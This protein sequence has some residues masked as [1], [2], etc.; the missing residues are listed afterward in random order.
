MMKSKLTA[1]LLAVLMTLTALLPAMAG[2][3]MLA[4]GKGGAQRE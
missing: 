1:G 4:F 2:A 3:L